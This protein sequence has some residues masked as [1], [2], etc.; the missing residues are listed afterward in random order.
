MLGKF[1]LSADDISFILVEADLEGS[2][3]VA[4]ADDRILI[5][6]AVYH[7]IPILIAGFRDITEG[8]YSIRWNVEGLKLWYSA[9]A[10]ELGLDDLLIIKPTIKDA[11][12]RW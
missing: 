3:E 12:F 4:T 5:K 11:S 2:D 7:Q 8:G 6:T 1:G 9:L 10:S